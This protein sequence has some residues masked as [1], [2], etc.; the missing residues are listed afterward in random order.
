MIAPAWGA[1]STRTC[2]SSIAKAAREA[3]E[4][5]FWAE[6]RH[7]AWNLFDESF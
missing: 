7:R 1:F 6:E 2:I 4:N 5:G 3:S